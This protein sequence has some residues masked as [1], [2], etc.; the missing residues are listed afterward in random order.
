[1]QPV[2]P[3]AGCSGT[4]FVS[5][6]TDGPQVGARSTFGGMLSL[7]LEIP[8]REG[9][10]AFEVEG[11]WMRGLMV[12]SSFE[13]VTGMGGAQLSFLIEATFGLGGAS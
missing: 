11:G 12:A 9:A 10:L 7:R 4:G 5:D 1:M 6:C 13:P 2:G 8:I 3:A